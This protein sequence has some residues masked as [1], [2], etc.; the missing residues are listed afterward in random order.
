MPR[1]TQGAPCQRRGNDQNGAARAFL[2]IADRGVKDER[3]RQER[4]RRRKDVEG[5]H[6]LQFSRQQTYGNEGDGNGRGLEDLK[7][8]LPTPPKGRL[9]QPDQEHRTKGD[10]RQ[11]IREV[12]ERPEHPVVL[13]RPSSQNRHK[14]AAEGG[15]SGADAGGDQNIGAHPP[16][17]AEPGW[18][19]EQAADRIGIEQGDEAVRDEGDQELRG[20]HAHPDFCSD[21]GDE[22][23]RDQGQPFAPWSKQECA[24]EDD[25]RWPEQREN[26]IRKRADQKGELRAEIIGKPDQQRHPTAVKPTTR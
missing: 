26:L 17:G 11:G 2:P 21:V 3:Q 25:V 12:P 24:E 6:S 4:N 22:G 18:R 1:H 20:R 10:A 7:W 16:E 15:E 9:G 13:D 5:R 14:G 23:R 8:C 19:I